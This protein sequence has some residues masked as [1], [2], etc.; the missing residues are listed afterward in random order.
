[1]SLLSG[2]LVPLSLLPRTLVQLAPLWPSWH[3]A[4]LAQG[5]VGTV[6]TAGIGWHLLALAAMSGACLA[7]AW[8][9]LGKT[10]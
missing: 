3:L 5:V 9:A 10:R 1:M 2:L 4:Q 8:R 6:P 7:G